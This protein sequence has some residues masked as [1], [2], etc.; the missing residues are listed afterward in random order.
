MTGFKF[1]DTETDATRQLEFD[2]TDLIDRDEVRR[3]MGGSI[4]FDALRRRGGP[5]ARDPDDRTRPANEDGAM[6]A[7][8][9]S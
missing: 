2:E 9:H 4:G 3:L 1:R 8:R 6:D 5:C 7:R